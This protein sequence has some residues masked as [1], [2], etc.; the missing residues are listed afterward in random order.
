[1]EVIKDSSSKS[2]I[3]F[4]TK[5]PLPPLPMCTMHI[6]EDKIRLKI[7]PSKKVV[8]VIQN[9][10]NPITLIGVLKMDT[11]YYKTMFLLEEISVK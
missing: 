1:M 10:K 2:Q 5:N 9:A 6:A 3:I 7:S 11:S 4:L 8:K